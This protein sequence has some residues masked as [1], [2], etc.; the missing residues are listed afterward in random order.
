MSS[1]FDY[2]NAILQNK[3]QLIVDE[4]TEKDY[5]PFLVNRSLSYHKDCLMYANEMNQRHFLDKKLQFDFLLNTVRS[6]KRPFAKWIKSEK[7]DDLECIKQVYGF[8]DSK[9]LEA[10]RLLSKEQIQQLK[11]QTDIG[12]LRK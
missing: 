1:P 5:A 3:K 10:F 8:S 12:G 4:I 6:Q 9:A 7:S 2:V 11:E